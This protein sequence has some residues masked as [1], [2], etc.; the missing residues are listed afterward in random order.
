MSTVGDAP[1]F[2]E[3]RGKTHDA[4]EHAPRNPAFLCAVVFASVPLRILASMKLIVSAVGRAIVA[5]VAVAWSGSSAFLGTWGAGVFLLLGQMT[6]GV[7]ANPDGYCVKQPWP[8]C[9]GLLHVFTEATG[10]AN[11][12]DPL[13]LEP[14][15]APVFVDL[16]EDGFVDMIVGGMYWGTIQVRYNSGSNTWPDVAT[17]VTSPPHPW[18]DYWVETSPGSGDFRVMAGEVNHRRYVCFADLTG[19]D[20]LDFITGGKDGNIRV[21]F[22][23]GSN[24][25]PTEATGAA[26][27]FHLHDVGSYATPTFADIN[28]DG[29]IDLIAGNSDGKIK[30]WY[31]DGTNAWPTEATGSDNPFGTF[32]TLSPS[33]PTAYTHTTSLLAC[34]RFDRR[35]RQLESEVH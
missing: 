10:A 23:S 26:N 6:R 2:L 35:R 27:P 16:D 29:F 11:P 9:D 19:D 15:A 21:W 32:L 33:H 31:N 25:W 5:L 12:F 1:S 20:K 3:L 4:D 30:V 8:R 34:D 7:G 22:N 28:N 14:G 17:A 24:T 13:L 18:P